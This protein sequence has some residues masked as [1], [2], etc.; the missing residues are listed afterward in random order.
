MLQP[1]NLPIT[2]TYIIYT[3]DTKHITDYL[4]CD[5]IIRTYYD[6]KTVKERAIERSKQHVQCD[7]N[8]QIIETQGA[9]LKD[10]ETE[11]E[12]KAEEFVF[13]DVDES[14]DEFMIF[15]GKSKSSCPTRLFCNYG[16]DEDGNWIYFLNTREA[17]IVTM[18]KQYVESGC[19]EIIATLDKQLSYSYHPVQALC[20]MLDIRFRRTKVS[21]QLIQDAM[22]M[23][24]TLFKPAD[25]GVAT[26]NDIACGNNMFGLGLWNTKKYESWQLKWIDPMPPY[27][28]I[29]KS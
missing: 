16:Q 21:N 17:E 18:D 12:E 9:E 8:D 28:S 19:D 13:E 11:D 1:P 10:E 22:G 3:G 23:A 6:Y 25:D 29:R 5:R 14:E 26:V 7:G 24:E 20:V 15:Q 2:N 27:Y 4:L